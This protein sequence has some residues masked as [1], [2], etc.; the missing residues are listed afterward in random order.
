M[1]INR[2]SEE[3]NVPSWV[4]ENKVASNFLDKELISQKD[5][6]RIVGMSKELTEEAMVMEKDRIEQCAGSKESYHY[7]TQWKDNVKSELKEYASVVGM[8]MN[9]FKAVNPDIVKQ[10]SLPSVKI[11]EKT[12]TDKKSMIDIDAFK[13]DSI[14]E[15]DAK[16]D[17]E[18][19]QGQS[20]M[21]D[22]PSANG[23][24]I[25]I[26]NSDDYYKNSNPK[27]ARGR[28]S[29]LDADAIEKMAKNSIEDN[30]ARLKR[31][32]EEKAMDKK[33][34]HLKWQNSK[35]AAMEEKDI[36]P[37]RGKVYPTE[38]LNAQPGIRGEDPFD[39]SK[40]PEKSDG[41]KIKE[42]NAKRSNKREF[43][44]EKSSRRGVSEDFSNEL[45]K[46]MVK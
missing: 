13:L 39:Y 5:T 16:N 38:S 24:V 33:V 46:F 29:I 40:M 21:S 7:N 26:R 42:V 6:D 34:E 25:S 3:N 27:T 45:K 44:I 12:E 28:N 17:W 43:K 35:I 9:K 30:G 36:I 10:T 11:A 32:K 19:I 31:E 4:T 23:S 15:A 37:N 2:M 14:K 20:N 41:E 8:D 1:K 22:K 18:K